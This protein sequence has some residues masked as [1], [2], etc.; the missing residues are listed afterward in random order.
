VVLRINSAVRAQLST[1]PALDQSKIIRK[2]EELALQLPS[3]RGL[4]RIS[5]AAEDDLW[6]L[7]ISSRIRVLIRIAND[8]FDVLAVARVDQM[9]RYVR[10]LH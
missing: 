9:E 10:R 6:E 3:K 4:R 1:M 7:R 2:L 8:Q 5:A